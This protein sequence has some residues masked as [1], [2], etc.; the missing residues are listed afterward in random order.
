MR[1]FLND[2]VGDGYGMGIDLDNP[3]YGHP[4]GDLGFATDVRINVETGDVAIMLSADAAAD[5]A[6]TY[7]VLG[8]D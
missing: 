7:D 1:A 8:G 3:T 4:G 2:P 5:T 6:W